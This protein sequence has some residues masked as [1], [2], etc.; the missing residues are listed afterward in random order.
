MARQSGITYE[1]HRTGHD[2]EQV[3]IRSS[4]YVP[5][6]VTAYLDPKKSP[7]RAGRKSSFL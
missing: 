3:H 1:Q 2:V 5:L 7:G 6:N 4:I